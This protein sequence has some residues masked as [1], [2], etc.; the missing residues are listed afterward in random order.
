MITRDVIERDVVITAC[1]VSAGIHAALVPDHLAE[2]TAA[3]VGF[4][5]AALLLAAAAVALTRRRSATLLA[6]TAALLVG[7]LVSYAFAVTTGVPVLHPEAEPLDGLALV[8]KAVELLGLAAAAD[9]LARSNP[10]LIRRPKG[11]FA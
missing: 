4:A 11:L 2:G 8:T 10:F 1:A 9:L 3:G 5:V 7:L 6:A